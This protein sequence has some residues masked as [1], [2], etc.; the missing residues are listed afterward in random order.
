MLTAAAVVT[1]LCPAGHLPHKG[2]DRQDASSSSALTLPLLRQ[3][4]TFR[5]GHGNLALGLSRKL[6]YSP[7][8]TLVGE[9]PGRAEGGKLRVF[10]E[11]NEEHEMPHALIPPRRRTNAKRMRATMTDAE[12]KLWNAIRAHRLMDL[13]FRRQVPIAGYIVDFACSSHRLIVEVDGSQHGE[14]ADARYDAMRT[15]RLEQD[16]WIVLRFWND[17]VLRDIDNACLHILKVIGRA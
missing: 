8:S 5:V 10:A 3:D 2:G 15:K 14:A 17:E 13:G 11:L 4:E 6:R 9:M 16:G 12:L 7:I 1:P